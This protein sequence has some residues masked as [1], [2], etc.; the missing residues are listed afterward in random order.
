M[1]VQIV[2]PDRG[3]ALVGAAGSASRGV[4]LSLAGLAERA[5]TDLRLR[6]LC[7]D[8]VDAVR[9]SRTGWWRAASRAGRRAG[10]CRCRSRI[11]AIRWS[12]TRT[13]CS[14]LLMYLIEDARTS[15]ATLGGVAPHA[16]VRDSHS[17]APPLAAC[18]RARPICLHRLDLRAAACGDLQPVPSLQR[19]GRSGAPSARA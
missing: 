15:G 14:E 12:T 7:G 13:T 3:S 10:W 6:A 11:I 17:T 1:P 9:R 16:A 18:S 19:S 4:G 5:A 2:R 8:D